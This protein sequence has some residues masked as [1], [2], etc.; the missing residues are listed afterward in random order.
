MVTN[1]IYK[2]YEKTKSKVTPRLFKFVKDLYKAHQISSKELG[3]YSLNINIF[4][5]S[6]LIVV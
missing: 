5:G 6:F 1:L 2:D 4:L 3:R